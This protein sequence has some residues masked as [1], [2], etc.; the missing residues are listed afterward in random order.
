MDKKIR[1]IGAAVL[2]AVWV[3][4]TGFAWFA[5]AKDI[6]D[7]ERRPLEQ[8]PGLTLETILDGSFMDKF[9]AY[10]LDQ[11]PG[12]DTFRQIKSIFH[13]YALQQKDNNNIYVVNG[14]AAQMEYTLNEAALN[15]AGKIFNIVYENNL[16]DSGCNIYFTIVPDKGYY[17]AEGNGYPTLDYDTLFAT[18]EENLPWAEFIDLTDTLKSTDY[19]YTDPHWRQEHLIPA[20]QKIANAMGITAPQESDYTK[21]L[22]DRPFYGYYYGTAALPMPAEDMYIMT[23][24]LLSQCKVYNHETN[25]YIDVYDMEKL[26]SKDL[27]DVFLSGPQALLTIENPNATTDKELIVFRDSFG[28]SMT[29]LLVQDYSKVTLVDIRYVSSRWLD[30]YITFDGQDVLF[31][32]N[33]LVLNEG[34][35]LK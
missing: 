2:V 31:L 16:K 19:Y 12:R 14:Y 4:L 29:P 10:T 20:A 30:R 7:A 1:A 24:E 21:V 22:L 13:Y 3:A 11:F 6:S 26:T 32:Y 9:E 15:Y 25:A 5:P 18:M 23:S 28:S 34:T 17:L 35:Q 27:Y 8:W 33:T